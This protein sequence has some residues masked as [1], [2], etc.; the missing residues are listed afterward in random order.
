M[1]NYTQFQS[2]LDK[3]VESGG[4]TYKTDA[5]LREYSTFRIGGNA[6]FIILPE[7]I[8]ALTRV[9]ESARECDIRHQVF[10]NGSNL[11]FADEG[12]RGAAIFTKK[13]D[14]CE[15]DGNIITFGCGVSM[16]SAA[17]MAQKH[18]LTGLEFLYGIPGTMGGGVYMN[19][20]AYG[21]EMAQVVATSRCYNRSTGDIFTLSAAAH[22]FDYRH[23]VFM[24]ADWIVL[25]TTLELAP[26]DSAE[27]QAKMDELMAARRD[28]QP[29][30]MPS[31]GSTFKRYPGYFTAQLIDEAGL[32]GLSV[33]GAQ[34]SPKHAGFV[35]NTGGATAA[36]VLDLVGII[37]KKIHELHGIVI[38]REVEYIAN[39]E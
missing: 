32:K 38:E 39:S 18:G 29:L 28:K 15:L 34:V 33:G 11:L 26:G 35:V 12:Y 21:G 24:D 22:R 1:P 30:D 25:S 23:S 36:D 13:M 37:A 20:G 14:F 4:L 19:A 6:D 8:E 7:T 2:A 27:I 16:T 17:I 9:L 3:L 5:S 10:G 31:A